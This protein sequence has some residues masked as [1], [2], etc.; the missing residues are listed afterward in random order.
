MTDCDS[1]PETVSRSRARAGSLPRVALQVAPS[2]IHGQ[3][4]FA[5]EDIAAGAVVGWC[6]VIPAKHPGAHTLWC[7]EGPVDVVCEL[8]FTNHS[9]TPNV[10]YYDTLRVVALRDIKCGEELT[11][12][13]GPNYQPGVDTE[14]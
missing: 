6:E 2:S 3:G 13:Y 12:N 14:C 9:T 7:D 1:P 11:Y 8:R 4:L 5:G 10:V